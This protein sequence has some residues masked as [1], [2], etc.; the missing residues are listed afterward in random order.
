MKSNNM[1]AYFLVNIPPPPNKISFTLPFASEIV[2]FLL[3][4]KFLDIF[5]NIYS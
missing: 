2:K 5:L 1:G 4:T 3:K